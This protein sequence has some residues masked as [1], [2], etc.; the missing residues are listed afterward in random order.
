MNGVTED[1]HVKRLKENGLRGMTDVLRCTLRM[2]DALA[3]KKNER[4]NLKWLDKMTEPLAQSFGDWRMRRV[5]APFARP[6]PCQEQKN[7]ERK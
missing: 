6:D 5:R 1:E 4:G 2:Q 3:E 7:S